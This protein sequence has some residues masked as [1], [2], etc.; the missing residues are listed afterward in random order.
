MYVCMYIYIISNF[1]VVVVI[2][3]VVSY[4]RRLRGSLYRDVGFYGYYVFTTLTI[5]YC[6]WDCL[7]DY[8]RSYYYNQILIIMLCVYTYEYIIIIIGIT[9]H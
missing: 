3:S 5:V 7:F 8:K 6:K 9:H 1:A 2:I 4:Q